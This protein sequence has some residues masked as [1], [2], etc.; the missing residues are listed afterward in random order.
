[1]K[2][3]TSHFMGG[4][5]ATT[6]LTAMSAGAAF[7]QL[8]E[9]IVTAE[10]REASLQD[11]ALSISAF[12]ESQI[13]Q[14]GISDAYDIGAHIPS[15]TTA[16][17]P[18]SISAVSFYIRG[19]GNGEPILTAEQ[20][21]GVYVDGAVLARQTGSLLDIIDLE[22]VEVL[23]GPQGSLYGRNTTGGAI[24]FIT[25][26][27][28]DE[29]EINQK[30]SY[31]N[32]SYW[33]SKTSIDTGELGDS[34][35]R[36]K[37]TYLHKER[38]GIVDDV[39]SSKSTDPGSFDIDAFRAALSWQ[40][41]DSINVDYSFDFSNRQGTAPA[42]QTVS[43]SA[44][45]AGFTALS[46]PVFGGKNHLVSPGA[47]LDEIAFDDDATIHDEVRG[48]NLN[49]TW[50]GD[51]LT[52]KSI[53]S[54]RD[55]HNSQMGTDLDGQSDDVF[56]EYLEF[57]LVPDGALGMGLDGIPDTAPRIA[58]RDYNGF[59]AT[60]VRN[61]DQWSQEFQVL[62]N[63]GERF[64]F[65]AGAYYFREE[66]DEDNPQSFDLILPEA[67][68]ESSFGL[69]AGLISILAH[70]LGAPFGS[71]VMFDPIT[72]AP[73]GG[74]GTGTNFGL[75][76][77]R[78]GNHLTYSTTGK[79]WALFGQA[80]YVPPILDDRMTLSYGMRY[81]E[82]RRGFDQ[83]SAVV[84]S[85]NAKFDSFNYDAS[86]NMSWTDD[87][88]TY[89][90]IATGY[91]AGGF[92]PRSSGN[93]S[94]DDENLTTYE[95]GVKSE[96]F[97]RRVRIN[98]SVFY[99]EYDDIQINQFIAGSGGA[100]SITLNAGESETTGF[101][102]EILA[103]PVDGLTFN[104]GIGMYDPDFEEYLVVNPINDLTY[105]MAASAASGGGAETTINA[106]IQYDFPPMSVGQLSMRLDYMYES[107]RY[108]HPI[109]NLGDAFLGASPA[110][111]LLGLNTAREATKSDESNK[112][113]ARISLS[114]V[115]I[116]DTDATMVIS[117]WG[118]NITDEETVG[119]GIDFG[120]LGFTGVQY[121]EPATYGID[122]SIKY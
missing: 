20:P 85:G 84:R 63:I 112:L 18:S 71:G 91:K 58:I 32:Y 14:L 19:I 57:F 59:S 6:M 74:S 121:D 93:N 72:G 105:N 88:S 100:S 17:S 108:H 87:F 94:F 3:R 95:V 12:N 107:E 1:M 64:D 8:D 73:S 30:F 83:T 41:T 111:P 47:R 22:R 118:K 29:Q 76:G 82:D 15:L 13:E 62:G 39:N 92:N 79:S 106:G 90:R 4:L 104:A 24:N 61:Q 28:G 103:V 44:V 77:F 7:A 11:T 55:W 34:G 38:D 99:N 80:K 70:P 33:Q 21:V 46:A 114:D 113:N 102:V 53:T 96:W 66:G 67:F 75:I 86:V 78:I 51:N 9:I 65:V 120:G 60:N 97:D 48:H 2:T 23:R 117:V 68:I 115:A 25:K 54:Y 16:K 43:T 56:G 42:F 36:T 119:W 98:G 10:K 50:E 110:M 27:P 81:T 5:M 89:A 49:I 109:T 35:V 116:A 69:P 45:I 37:F 26:R 31:G 40:A 52:F 101:E 122:V